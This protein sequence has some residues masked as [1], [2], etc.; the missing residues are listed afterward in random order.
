MP[1]A[2]DMIKNAPHHDPQ[3]ELSTRDE[4]EL[5]SHYGV[6]Y[7]GETVTAEPGQSGGA[8]PQQ[9]QRPDRGGEAGVQGRD[10]SGPTTDDAMT[11]SEERLSVGTQQVESGRA[12][13]A[14]TS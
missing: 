12:G 7:S 14:S 13:C 6:P 11:R 1:Y 8:A 10:T 2:K 3:A 4:A 9:G 5:F